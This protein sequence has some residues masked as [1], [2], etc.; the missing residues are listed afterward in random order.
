MKKWIPLILTTILAGWIVSSFR[1]F[2]NDKDAMPLKEFG[3][4]PILDHGRHQPLDSLARNS[5]LILRKKQR[6]NLE[7]WKGELGGPKIVPAIE[8]LAEL[9]MEPEVANTRPCFRIDNSDVKN[10]L[11]LPVE[12]DEKA[13][14]DGKH[15]SWNQI[16]AKMDAFRV[17]TQRAGQV[18]A[19][20]RS[21]YER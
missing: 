16:E 7:P 21:A 13:Q 10:L 11:Q 17:E 15:Y 14:Q 18:K 4:L 5:L 9:M 19:E 20:V 12:A 3:K 2:Q 6:L 1:G 8:W